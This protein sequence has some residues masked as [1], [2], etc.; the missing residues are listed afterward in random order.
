MNAV[1]GLRCGVAVIAD[2]CLA[3]GV[4]GAVVVGDDQGVAAELWAVD[5]TRMLEPKE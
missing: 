1:A 4:K 3:V 5:V 2:F